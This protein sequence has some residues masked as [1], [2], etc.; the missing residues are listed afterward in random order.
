MADTY[1]PTG[2]LTLLTVSLNCLEHFQAT[3]ASLPDHLP[4][5]LRWIVV[6]GGS[7][8]GTVDAI[9]SDPRVTEWISEK[10]GGV[11]DAYNKALRMASSPYVLYLNSGDTL[12][13][14][15]SSLLAGW[16]AAVGQD[17]GRTVHCFA[18]AMSYNGRVW[19]PAPERLPEGMSVPTPG[20]L[21]PRVAVEQ[22]GGFDTHLRVA[23]DFDV[24]LALHTAGWRFQVHTEV[25]TRYLGGGLS[26]RLQHLAFFEEC[27]IQ[28]RHSAQTGEQVLLRAA[29]RAVTDVDPRSTP[30]RRWRLA[31]ALGKRFL[32]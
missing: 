31:L 14:D 13:G 12:S 26:T 1:P 24:L 19:V 21:F 7:T 8:D 20:V 5:W 16:H 32:Y 29:R 2:T 23:S 27:M 30:Y 15:A 9:R 28:L 10:D 25:L 6:D 17:N 11:Y 18:V 4:S 22:A 3:S